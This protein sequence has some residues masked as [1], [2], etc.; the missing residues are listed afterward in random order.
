[1][2]AD[3]PPIILLWKVEDRISELVALAPDRQ[4]L[5][6]DHRELP[7]AAAQPV[8]RDVH[9]LL[10]AVD[11]EGTRRVALHV[12]RLARVAELL[13][14]DAPPGQEAA[15]EGFGD[16]G[17]G[18]SVQGFFHALLLPLLGEELLDRHPPGFWFGLGLPGL[19]LDRGQLVHEVDLLG[20]S[21]ALWQQ[22]GGEAGTFLLLNFGEVVLGRRCKLAFFVELQRQCLMV[23]PGGEEAAAVGLLFL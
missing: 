7:P 21:W 1:M 5:F 19:R 15:L 2:T 18:L 6:H 13:L 12:H 11:V 10:A 8:G 4:V 20:P 3:I 14:A 16:D 17:D 22:V 9:H 23:G